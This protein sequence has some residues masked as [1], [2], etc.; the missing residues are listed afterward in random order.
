MA[1][2]LEAQDW[3]TE[4]FDDIPDAL[5]TN[6]VIGVFDQKIEDFICKYVVPTMVDRVGS[7]F[8]QIDGNGNFIRHYF[9]EKGTKLLQD[10]VAAELDLLL[11][12][13]QPEAV[14]LTEEDKNRII[15]EVAALVDQGSNV[16]FDSRRV[17]N[18][19]GSGNQ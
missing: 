17:R 14:F 9:G 3:E 18:Q 12:H 15:I 7:I 19:N 2:P 6:V 5:S 16:V 10:I 4:I 13:S 11:P 1:L 8:Y